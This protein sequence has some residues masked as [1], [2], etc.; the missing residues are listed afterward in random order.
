MKREVYSIILAARGIFPS[1]GAEFTSLLNYPAH[2]GAG[3][4]FLYTK[5][6]RSRNFGII[7]KIGSDSIIHAGIPTS[8][9]APMLWRAGEV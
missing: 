6:P 9:L 1:G 2:G 3:K 5:I 8:P 4:Y 7:G